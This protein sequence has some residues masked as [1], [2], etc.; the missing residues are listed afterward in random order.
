M[1]GSIFLMLAVG[2]SLLLNVGL[3]V[4][5]LS[6][7]PAVQASP[8]PTTMIVPVAA[9]TP[10]AVVVAAEAEPVGEPAAMAL[11][12]RTIESADYRQYIT[13][14]RALG[15][16]EQVIQDIIVAD[17]NQNYT[18]RAREIWSPRVNKY[19]QKYSNERPNPQQTEQLL[20]LH[21][22]QA[23][24]IK[25]LLGVRRDQ[26]GLI[27]TLHVQL[28]GS[29]Q[30]LLFLPADR[31]EAA[32]QALADADFETKE[33]RFQMRSSY[34][35]KDEQKLFN[36]KLAVLKD[37]LSPEELESFRQ[38]NSPAGAHLKNEVRY[39]NLTPAEYQQLLLA[40]EA[41]FGEKPTQ[42]LV[43]KL[44]GA[45]RAEE[46]QRTSSAFYINAR[47]GAEAEGI[48]L[49]RVEQVAKLANESMTSG[50]ALIQ[51]KTLSVETRKARLAELQAQAE[52]EIQSLLGVKASKAV[53]R[54]LRN[55][56]RSSAL[57]IRP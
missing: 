46:F 14:L 44:F 22:E 7:K 33:A 12:W 30:Q 43:Q 8:E 38:R 6:R 27:D 39:L 18:K 40:K 48:S 47:E 37:V 34:A 20:A 4:H 28:H 2:L 31:R 55:V 29:E 13:N 24:T 56:L 3:I 10:S 54:D 1:K 41:S 52:R 26:Q 45:E 35:T 9:T 11:D 57:Q 49:V 25:E 17:L 21:K 23:A 15:V 53:V 50:L 32:L 16:P 36:E 5:W 42:E 51:D 19:W